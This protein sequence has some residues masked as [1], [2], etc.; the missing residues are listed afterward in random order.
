MSSQAVGRRAEAREPLGL[1]GR[2][3][4]GGRRPRRA[5]LRGRR[6]AVAAGAAVL[7]GLAMAALRSDLLRMRYALSE[8]MQRERELLQRRRELVARVRALRDPARLARLAR[9]RGFA[10]PERVYELEP[11]RGP[12]R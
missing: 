9:E 1:V 5:P 8:A 11:P 10:R 7:V 4:A 3:V 12:A 6:L 2:D